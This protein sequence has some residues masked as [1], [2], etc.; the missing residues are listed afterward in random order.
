MNKANII[1]ITLHSQIFLTG[2]HGKT[3]YFDSFG[4][5]GLPSSNKVIGLFARCGVILIGADPHGHVA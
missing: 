3:Q 5:S 2:T 4:R 1:V